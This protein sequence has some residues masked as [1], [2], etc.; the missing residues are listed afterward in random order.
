MKRDEWEAICFRC[1]KCCYEKVDLGGG[2]IRYLDEPCKFLDTTTKLCKV[3]HSRHEAEPDCI[4]LTEEIVRS[5]NW[6]P[7]GCA[8]VER[9]RHQDTLAAVRGVENNKKRRRNV[10]RRNNARKNT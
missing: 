6:L 10:K 4:S 5:L 2:V 3:Y 1:G 9:L 8:Y 7:E